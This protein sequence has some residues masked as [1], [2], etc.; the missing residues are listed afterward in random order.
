[1]RRY[2][3]YLLIARVAQAAGWDYDRV[4]LPRSWACT[5]YIKYLCCRQAH[6]YIRIWAWFAYL[7]MYLVRK[8]EG[9]GS[10]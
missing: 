5:T 8:M 9:S 6:I 2:L 10:V 4:K 1:M 3:R 7:G